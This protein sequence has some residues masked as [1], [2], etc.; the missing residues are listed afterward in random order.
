MNL[1]YFIVFVDIYYLDKPTKNYIRNIIDTIFL[2][3]RYENK[4]GDRVV[5]LPGSEEIENIIE[6]LKDYINILKSIIFSKP[7]ERFLAEKTK[8]EIIKIF[9]AIPKKKFKKIL[10]KLLLKNSDYNKLQNKMI[11]SQIEESKSEIKMYV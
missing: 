1:N 10:K 11:K 6:L 3:H 9:K 7:N 2:I 4:C 5:F 8:E